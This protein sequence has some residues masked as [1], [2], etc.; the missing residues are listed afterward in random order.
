MHFPFGMLLENL[1]SAMWAVAVISKQN[2]ERTVS[3]F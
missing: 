3:P 2:M 1:P